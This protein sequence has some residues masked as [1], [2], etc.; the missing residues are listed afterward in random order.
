MLI[1]ARDLCPVVT[2]AVAAAGDLLARLLGAP[3]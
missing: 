1:S 3:Y 2:M